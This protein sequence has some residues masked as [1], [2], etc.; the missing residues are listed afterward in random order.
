MV[1]AAG[2]ADVTSFLVRILKSQESECGYVGD[3]Q[4][5]YN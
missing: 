2:S 5:L 4:E 3:V 1:W